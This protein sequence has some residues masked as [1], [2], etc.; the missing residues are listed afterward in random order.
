MLATTTLAALLASASALPA[1]TDFG[2]RALF[3]GAADVLGQAVLGTP[4][5]SSA[6]NHL[7]FYARRC[8]G[9][10]VS[11]GGRGLDCTQCGEVDAAPYMPA[12]IF[13][14]RNTLALAAYVEVTIKE[15][16]NPNARGTPLKLGR[17]SSAGFTVPDGEK[18]GVSWWGAQTA[19]GP[20]ITTFMLNTCRA[21]CNCNF[22]GWNNGANGFSACKDVPDDPRAG[23]WC[24]LCGPT[25]ACP[26]CNGGYKV[27]ISLFRKPDSPNPAPPSPSP[28]TPPATDSH[29]WFRLVRPVNRLGLPNQGFHCGEVDAAPRMPASIFEPSNSAALDRYKKVTIKGVTS[30]IGGTFGDGKGG[31]LKGGTLE[32]GRCAEVG[33]GE[34]PATARSGRSSWTNGI[35][36]RGICMVQC[37]CRFQDPFGNNCDDPAPDQPSKSL[38]C[39][40]C[41][42]SGGNNDFNNIAT[43][44]FYVKSTK[45]IVATAVATPALSTLVA[46]VKAADLVATLSSPGPFTVFAPTNDAF[47]AIQSV[48]DTLLKPENKAKL[49][50]LLTYHVLAG[51]VLAAAIKNGESVATVEGQKVCFEVNRRTKAV[52]VFPCGSTKRA[53]QVVQADVLATN[54]VVHVI[55]QVLVPNGFL[56]EL[57]LSSD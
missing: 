33:Y 14:P 27:E 21:K 42:E 39:S 23:E 31:T 40:L 8:T 34:V 19:A 51:Q 48:V 2:H 15:Y 36:M 7:Y 53:A 55:D 47:A 43:I 17:C 1:A 57:Y 9:V 6:D 44:Q 52:G 49:A 24:S 4:A 5:A 35:D 41:V 3:Q 38:F 18:D 46:A 54:G 56:D 16:I 30:A 26:S 50:K 10:P 20:Q 32:V 28:P 13:Q 12:A 11:K 45:N 37:N 25:T 29:L 22:R